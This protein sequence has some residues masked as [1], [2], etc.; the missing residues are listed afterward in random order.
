MRT[1][2]KE[3]DAFAKAVIPDDAS[4]SQCTAM[5]KAF[6]SGAAVMYILSVLEPTE[7]GVSQDDAIEMLNAL[8]LEL[9][10]D[11]GI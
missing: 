5:K 2:K 7:P 11:I 6:Y 8:Y 9:K 3:W 10:N 1:I 4:E